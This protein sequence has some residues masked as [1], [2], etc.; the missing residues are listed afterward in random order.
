MIFSFTLFEQ[1]ILKILIVCLLKLKY[2]YNKRKFLTIPVDHIVEPN[3]HSGRIF[4]R[5]NLSF[6]EN[7][8]PL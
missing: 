8:H 7:L 3:T 5:L 4:I 2:Y 6:S 1:Y